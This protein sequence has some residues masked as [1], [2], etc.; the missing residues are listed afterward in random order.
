MN[1]IF[2]DFSSAKIVANPSQLPGCS[3]CRPID[4][5]WHCSMSVPPA[6]PNV[7]GGLATGGKSTDIDILLCD[8]NN[9]SQMANALTCV[10]LSNTRYATHSRSMK[11]VPECQHDG[12]LCDACCG[13]EIQVTL[14]WWVTEAAKPAF[15]H[16]P[17]QCT[18]LVNKGD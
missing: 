17:L 7:H 14:A 16:L 15:R 12:P 6:E 18:P 3:S 10:V 5:H 13:R 1:C 4:A 8:Q 2:H 9:T 11:S